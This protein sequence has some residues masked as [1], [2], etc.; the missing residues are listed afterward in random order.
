MVRRLR[1][2]GLATY[3]RVLLHDDVAWVSTTIWDSELSDV[4][5]SFNLCGYV[6]RCSRL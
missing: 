5:Y 6:Y 1:D 4:L 3:G 2:D